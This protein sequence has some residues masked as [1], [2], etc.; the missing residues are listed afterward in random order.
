MKV[1]VSECI[2]MRATC[3]FATKC[4]KLVFTRFSKIQLMLTPL[5]KLMR[6]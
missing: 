3:A 5:T 2:L 4:V 1:Y 6:D